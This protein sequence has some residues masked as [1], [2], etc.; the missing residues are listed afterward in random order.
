M[1]VLMHVPKF[2][3]SDVVLSVCYLINR[4]PLS[5]LIGIISFSCLYPNKTTFFITPHVF[6]CTCFIQD[7]S[8]ELDK[9]S[10]K[11]IKWVF[12]GYSRTEKEYRIYNP[13][14]KYLASV[15]VTFFEFIPYFSPQVSVTI[16]EIVP[17]SL[18]VSLPTPA[19]TISL[20]VPPVETPDPPAS[21]P[22]RDFRYVY[23]HCP[24]VPTP[25]QFRLIPL[26]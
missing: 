25:N 9:L 3:W 26:Q 11:S 7:L 20:P 13:S 14:T 19:S 22:V 15:D 1:M 12:V 17:P 10:S 8:P 18:S 5:V 24:K 4:M 21:K 16:S 6:S 23:T 2:L